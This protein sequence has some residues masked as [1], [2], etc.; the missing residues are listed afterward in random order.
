MAILDKMHVTNLAIKLFICRRDKY[1][2]VPKRYSF[3]PLVGVMSAKTT[4]IELTS[5]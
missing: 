3:I 4:N 1:N 5:V 2:F